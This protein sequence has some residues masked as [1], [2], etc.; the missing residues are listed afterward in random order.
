L[1]GDL[2]HAFCV[3]GK[4][5]EKKKRDKRENNKT[6]REEERRARR[7]KGEQKREKRERVKREKREER[8]EDSTP[9]AFDEVRLEI[10]ISCPWKN[11]PTRGTCVRKLSVRE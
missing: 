4:R 10:P 8:E 2:S 7:E 1:T 6:R 11:E 5:G 9:F 3:G